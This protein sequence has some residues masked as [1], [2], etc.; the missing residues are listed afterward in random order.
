VPPLGAS[1]SLSNGGAILFDAVQVLNPQLCPEPCICQLEITCVLVHVRG[2]APAGGT[3]LYIL[4]IATFI[5]PQSSLPQPSD[6][7]EPGYRSH[8]HDRHGSVPLLLIRSRVYPQAATHFTV[9]VA[10]QPVIHLAVRSS[11]VTQSKPVTVGDGPSGRTT[12]HIVRP[13]HGLA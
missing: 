5:A 13:L 12:I 6:S 4:S 7:Y 11:L 9:V 1:P 3:T 2:L 10:S 8:S